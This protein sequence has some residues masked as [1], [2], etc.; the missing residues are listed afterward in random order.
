MSSYVCLFSTKISYLLSTTEYN[1]Q[2]SVHEWYLWGN[3]RGPWQH[4]HELL[5]T[6]RSIRQDQ[7]MSAITTALRAYQRNTK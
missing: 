5:C 7:W 4:C 2:L 3:S 6:T 1:M